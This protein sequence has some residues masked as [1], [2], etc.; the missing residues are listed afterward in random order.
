MDIIFMNFKK[1]ETSD[2]HRLLPNLSFKMKVINDLSS[3][4]YVF[5]SNL[6][7]YCT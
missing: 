1:S 6:S 4:K 5:L 2:A 3:D 7:F